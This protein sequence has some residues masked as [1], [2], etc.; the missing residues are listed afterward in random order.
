MTIMINPKPPLNMS[1]G[2]TMMSPTILRAAG[3]KDVLKQQYRIKK[4]QYVERKVFQ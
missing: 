1:G 4:Q 3:S 2:F